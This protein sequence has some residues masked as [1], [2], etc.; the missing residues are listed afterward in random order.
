MRALMSPLC[1]PQN[2]S[3]Y[4]LTY[5]KKQRKKEEQQSREAIF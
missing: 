1:D 3:E 2:E 4:R 5:G